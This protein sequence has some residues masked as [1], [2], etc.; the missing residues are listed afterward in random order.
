MT[1]LS[2]DRPMYVFKQPMFDSLNDCKSYVTVKSIEIYR[3][4][5]ASYNFRLKPEAIWC[6]DTDKMKELFKYEYDESKTPKQN[7]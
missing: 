1:S 6:I 4:A 7:I 2:I 5:S 3:A